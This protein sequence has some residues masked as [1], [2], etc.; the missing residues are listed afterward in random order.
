MARKSRKHAETESLIRRNAPGK[1]YQTA[2]YVRIS[3][4]NER[5]IEADSIGNQ[6][7]MLKDMVSQMPELQIYDIY[8][9]DNIT[10]T[11][12]IRPEFSRM[13]NDVRERNVNCIMVKD[14]SRLGRNYLESGEYLEKVFPFFG[15]RFIAINDRIDTLEK[16][17]DISAQLKNM[18]NEMYARDISRKICSTMKTLQEQGKFVG[19]HPPYGYMRNPEDKYSLV[20]D[21]ETAPIVREIFQKLADGYTVHAITLQLNERGIPSPGRYKFEK[22]L[23]KN[24]KFENSVWFFP[25]TRRILSD[26]IY[27]GWIQN[28]KYE[29]H[30]YKGG[31]K[32]VRVPKEEWRTIKGVHEPIVEEELFNRVQ[33]ILNQNSANVGRYQSKHNQNNIL[34]GKL[35]CGECGRSMTLRQRDSHGEKKMWYVC[36]IHESYNSSYCPKKAINKDSL[37]HM[38]LSVIRS[39]MQMY[40]D[41]KNLIVSSNQRAS[42]KGK[43]EIYQKQIR[44]VEKQIHQYTEK[45][46]ELYRDYSEHIITEEDYIAIGQDYSKKAD[47]LKIFL[48]ELRKDSEKYSENYAGNNPWENIFKEY[49]NQETLSRDMVEMMIEK[50]TVYNDGRTEISLRYKDELELVLCQAAVR[51]K[52]GA[53]YAV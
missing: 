8:C 9:D 13:M 12:F 53:R 26:S 15:I 11:T 34:R 42:G 35:V 4:E 17:V 46:A 31:N 38:V 21:P 10:G 48:A 52:E 43:Y 36:P 23:V 14:L 3:V 1:I 16:P 19:S 30:F 18:A 25:T 44:G 50:I 45:K 22:G 40:L 47:E 28:G 33:D 41:A 32:C 7:Q 49:G 20:R 2:L 27:L 37:E 24:S 51:E 6:I 39:Q 29:S 5:K